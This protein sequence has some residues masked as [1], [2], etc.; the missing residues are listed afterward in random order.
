MKSA[1]LDDTMAPDFTNPSTRRERV[2]NGLQPLK[3]G[4]CLMGIVNVT[5]DSFFAGSRASLEQAIERALHMWSMGATWVDIGGESTRPGATAI[6]IEEE[7]QRVVPVINALRNRGAKGLLSIDTRHAEVAEAALKAGAD[8]VNDVSGLRDPA[9]REVVI[10]HGCAVCIMH[11]QGAPGTMQENPRYDDCLS[12]VRNEL[13]ETAN[14]LV[15]QGHDPALILLDPG[16]GFGK[17]HQ[18]NLELLNAGRFLVKATPYR[19]LWGVSRK[20]VVGH[21]TGHDDPR[22]R[23]PGT[24]GMAMAAHHHQVDVL[25]VHDVEAHVDAFACY[26]PLVKMLNHQEE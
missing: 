24:L 16:I 18:H 2:M 20:S 21:L 17:T 11:M 13:V 12:E 1:A 4:P 10:R 25:R 5:D 23:L 7:I 8:M 22:D 9:M 19:L 14:H 6:S 26:T 3:D 15:N